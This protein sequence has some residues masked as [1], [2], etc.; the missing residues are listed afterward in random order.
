M[1]YGHHPHV[2]SP[3]DLT[4]LKCICGWRSKEL[5][6]SEKSDLGFPWYCDDCG[7]RV[8]HFITFHPS[9]RSA[10]YASFA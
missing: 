5:S 4:L 10:A 2:H 3:E 8:S 1:H 6:R 7:K 9:E